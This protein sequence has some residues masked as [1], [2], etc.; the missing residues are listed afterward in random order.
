MSVLGVGVENVHNFVVAA[1]DRGRS[2]GKGHDL[3][4]FW[5]DPNPLNVRLRERASPARPVGGCPL[6][7]KP[8][9]QPSE[10]SGP[11][12]LHAIADVCHYSSH[13][14]RMQKRRLAQP[15]P[16]GA[17]HCPAS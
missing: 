14:L 10:V 16:I 4:A 12:R 11:V 8:G 17:K 1:T 15:S 9:R 2:R 13:P 7:K 3:L 6:R 5:E